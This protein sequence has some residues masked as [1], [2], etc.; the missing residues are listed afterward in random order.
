MRLIEV[1]QAP[2]LERTVFA[3]A[4]RKRV[5]QV[6]KVLPPGGGTD[7]DAELGA[8]DTPD[9]ACHI[10]GLFA[11]GGRYRS[12]PEVLVKAFDPEPRAWQG[13]VLPAGA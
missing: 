4:P 10:E 7:V 11:I 1:E 13:V 6:A 2:R 12:V 3:L 5:R 8:V 9:A